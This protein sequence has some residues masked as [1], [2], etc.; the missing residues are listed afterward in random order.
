MAELP[1][2]ESE[3]RA[4]RDSFSKW[5]PSGLRRTRHPGPVLAWRVRCRSRRAR[6]SRDRW[7]SCVALLPVAAW[8]Y[9]RWKRSTERARARRSDDAVRRS[10]L[11]D[12]LGG[13][14]LAR[15]MAARA[16]SPDELKATAR[17]RDE[18]DRAH[19][20][21]LGALLRGQAGEAV[22]VRRVLVDG[23]DDALGERRHV[24]GVPRSG[25]CSCRSALTWSSSRSG[26]HGFLRNRSAPASSA[27]LSKAKW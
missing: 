2:Q 5:H 24:A 16:G 23:T 17:D 1:L 6:P 27:L 12:L 18:R 11:R 15:S 10:V 4:R 26:R 3:I 25:F 14:G 20:M 8:S 21:F 13:E 19:V 9:G 7:A 22:G